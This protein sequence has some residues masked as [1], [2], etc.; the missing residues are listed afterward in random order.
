MVQDSAKLSQEV[1]LSYFPT[2]WQH[3]Y[4]LPHVSPVVNVTE[5][6]CHAATI[7]SFAAKLRIELGIGSPKTNIRS[8]S[9]NI[10][11]KANSTFFALKYDSRPASHEI[12]WISSPGG[13]NG[14]LL[15]AVLQVDGAQW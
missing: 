15:K 7:V 9:Q 3:K 14:Q 2:L 10:D 11:S 1:R 6:F 4:H 8:H 12:L 13:G 5:V